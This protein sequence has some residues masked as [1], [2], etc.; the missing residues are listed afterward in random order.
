MKIADSRQ[1]RSRVHQNTSIL[2][3]PK[4]SCPEGAGE[5]QTAVAGA[6]IVAAE[7]LECREE[8]AG[9]AAA[10]MA[11]NSED[12]EMPMPSSSSSSAAMRGKFRS[13]TTDSPD[14]YSGEVI[15]A[16]A[17]S[18]VS[19]KRVDFEQSLTSGAEGGERPNN[20]PLSGESQA[21]I[22]PTR[23][24]F[25]EKSRDQR[26][27]SV[28]NIKY[29]P[30]DLRGGARA[31][32]NDV[33]P[34]MGGNLSKKMRKYGPHRGPDPQRERASVSLSLSLH[35]PLSLAESVPPPPPFPS[36]LQK[37]ERAS[38]RAV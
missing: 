25:K 33:S 17:A 8:D 38:G 1:H 7:A 23:Q 35:P 29:Q 2:Y 36:S 14:G 31:M 11:L 13:S 15:L 24:R 19:G 34:L 12:P 27:L 20:L 18:A 5:E 9:L 16:A 30:R 10:S 6:A 21:P 4:E 32:K 26:L 22:K 37:S 3:T 28:P